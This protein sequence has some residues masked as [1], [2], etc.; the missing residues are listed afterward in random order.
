MSSQRGGVT[1]SDVPTIECRPNGPYLV[2]GLSNLRN[3]SG[4]TLPTQPTMALCRCGG[5]A[6]KPFCD[7]THNRNGF[8]GQRTAPPASAT[9]TDYRGHSITIHDDRSICAH[10]GACTDGLP[11][12]FTYGGE[13]WIDPNGADLDAIVATIGQCPS[14]ALRYTLVA[15]TTAVE[16]PATPSITVTKNGPY[17]VVGGADVVDAANGLS[18]QRARLT[19]C[20]CGG[21][22]NKP[23]CDGSHWNNGFTDEKN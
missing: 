10:A 23:F 7:G 1:V 5:S 21:S 13:P 12:V 4:E 20:R 8:S 18:S 3:S 2:K 16:S 19:L 6:N 14:G 11:S 15:T 17:A 22:K 9:P